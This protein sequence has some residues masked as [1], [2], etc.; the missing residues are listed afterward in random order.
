MNTRITVTDSAG[1]VFILCDPNGSNGSLIDIVEDNVTSEPG[2]D[3]QI[4]KYFRG[5]EIEV[6]DRAQVQTAW[7]FLLLKEWANLANAEAWTDD[8]RSLCPRV[9]LVQKTKYD[10][11]GGASNRWLRNAGIS[12]KHLPSIGVATFT[13]VSII[14]GAVYKSA[15]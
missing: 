14:G 6:V 5:Q 3:L 10:Y 7:S 1:K 8:A 12:L 2:N 4:I 9:G 15:K 11:K 13:Q